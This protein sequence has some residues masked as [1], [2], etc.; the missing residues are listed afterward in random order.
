LQLRNRHNTI[1]T[2]AKEEAKRK[3]QVVA[4]LYH[5]SDLSLQN[6]AEQVDLSLKEV[7]EITND[8]LKSDALQL[9]VELSTTR[10]ESIMTRGVISLV[11]ADLIGFPTTSTGMAVFAVCETKNMSNLSGPTTEMLRLASHI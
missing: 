5:Y 10:V 7:R 6:I 4:S 3:K 1:P 9:L 8:L 2:D 11:N